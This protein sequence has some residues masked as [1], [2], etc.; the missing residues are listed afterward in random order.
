[1]L[2]ACAGGVASTHDAPQTEPMTPE[3]LVASCEAF[4]SS[5][6]VSGG[7]EGRQRLVEKL[8][9]H[10][11]HRKTRAMSVRLPACAIS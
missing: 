4:L 11:T 1:M 2:S 3:E 7:E 8:N 6:Q 10:F 9:I 5:C